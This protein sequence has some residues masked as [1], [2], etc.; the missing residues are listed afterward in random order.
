MGFPISLATKISGRD[1]GGTVRP[2]AEK[3]ESL[4]RKPENP[5][6]IAKT[7]ERAFAGCVI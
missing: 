4:R 1:Q 2:S 7:T 5:G 3:I 6:G